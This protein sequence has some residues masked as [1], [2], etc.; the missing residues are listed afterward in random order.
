L[1]SYNSDSG[2]GSDFL[3]V[4][5]PVPAPNLDHRKQIFQ[6]NLAFLHSKLFTRKKCIKFHQI[7]RKLVNEKILNE[8]N[9]LNNFISSSGSGFH[10]LTN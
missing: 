7:Y 3:Q 5:A 2:S 8:R 9:Q 10:F 1:A 4:T 6:N